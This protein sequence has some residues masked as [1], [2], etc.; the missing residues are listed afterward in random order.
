MMFSVSTAVGG[1]GSHSEA[2]GRIEARALL[3]QRK[4]EKKC[5]RGI[6]RPPENRQEEVYYPRRKNRDWC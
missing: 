5:R 1:T 6:A 4:N 2:K 3:S